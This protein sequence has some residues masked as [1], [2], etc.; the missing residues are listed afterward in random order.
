MVS[1]ISKDKP[2]TDHWTDHLGPKFTL[3][4]KTFI[5]FFLDFHKFYFMKNVKNYEASKKGK[6]ERSST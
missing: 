1:E 4:F 2:W 5:F 6:K 3:Y